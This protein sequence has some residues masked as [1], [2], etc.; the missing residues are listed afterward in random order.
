MAQAQ[1]PHLQVSKH[2]R[3]RAEVGD[4]LRQALPTTEFRAGPI[5]GSG[6]AS[7]EMVGYPVCPWL[8]ALSRRLFRRHGKSSNSGRRGL[9]VVCGK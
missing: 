6:S 4:I 2:L 9:S 8:H 5:I 3:S 7:F 1:V